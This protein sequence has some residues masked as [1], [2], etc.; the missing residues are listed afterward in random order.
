MLEQEIDVL[1]P[2]LDEQRQV[3]DGGAVETGTMLDD[4]AAEREGLD[5]VVGD[6]DLR[7][8]RRPSPIPP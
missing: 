1:T 4:P 3:T 6:E 5:L 8:T 2:T 7:R